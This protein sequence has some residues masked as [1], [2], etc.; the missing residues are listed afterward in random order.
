VF[1]LSIRR[2]ALCHAIEE[3]VSVA[4]EDS[5]FGDGKRN[6]SRLKLKAETQG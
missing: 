5:S 2:F 1:V 6:T 3:S 4:P